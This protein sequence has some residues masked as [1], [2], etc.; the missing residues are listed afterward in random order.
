MNILKFFKKKEKKS[1]FII[2]HYPESKLY[3]VKYKKKYL[4]RD[5]PTGLVGF[6]HTNMLCFAT[7]CIS[8]KEARRLCTLFK[9]QQLKENIKIIKVD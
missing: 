9:E 4:K 1:G 6:T 2:E 8:E 5:Y 7:D 3:Y